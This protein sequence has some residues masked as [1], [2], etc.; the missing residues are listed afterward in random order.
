M[1]QPPAAGSM[2]CY[3]HPGREVGRRCTRCGKPACHECLVQA[4]VGSHCIDC[5][6]AAR[7]DVTTRAK[8]WQARQPAM[9]TMTIIAINV[10]VFIYTT[11][12][13]PQSALG[14]ATSLGQAQLGLIGQALQDQPIGFRLPGNE[15]YVAQGPDWY[16]L[17]TSGFTHAGLIHIGFNMYLLWMLGNMLEPSIGRVRFALVYLASLLGG[18]ALVLVLSPDSLTVGASGAVFGLMGVA[19]IGYWLRGVNPLSTQI[20]S[21]LMLNLFITF[22]IPRVSIGGHLGGLLAGVACG[23]AVVAPAHHGRPKWLTYAAP[24]GVA[25][26]A[27]AV[28][29]ATVV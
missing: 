6:K 5:A 4:A 29:V 14:G 23:L 28:S 9:V 22:I 21:L 26:L 27:I 3:R 15:I 10:L 11:L 13:G 1:S 20:G 25:V 24:I 12:S 8:Y 7:P 16:R 19:A 17:V 18:S 2:T